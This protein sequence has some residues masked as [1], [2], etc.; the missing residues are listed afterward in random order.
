MASALKTH[1]TAPDLKLKWIFGIIKR[2]YL[3]GRRIAA[4]CYMRENPR[5]YG[6]RTSAPHRVN[7]ER[8]ASSNRSANAKKEQKGKRN[9]LLLLCI[10]LPPIGMAYIWSMQRYNMRSRIAISCLS[11]LVLFAG[12]YMMFYDSAGAPEPTVFLP[13]TGSIYAPASATEAPATNPA[14]TDMPYDIMVP[15]HENTDGTDDAAVADDMGEFDPNAFV[16]SG[17]QKSV[18]DGSNMGDAG[19]SA[20]VGAGTAVYTSENSLFYH[21]SPT[22]GDKNYDISMTL[23]EALNSGL[24]P[25]NRCNPPASIN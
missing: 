24:A 23:E 1:F 15:P 17:E 19:G 10:I 11:A 18:E 20:A 4:E 21:S 9:L 12:S 6:E 2:N 13:G 7:P 14:P 3:K 25:C 16:P 8:N 5:T 22:C